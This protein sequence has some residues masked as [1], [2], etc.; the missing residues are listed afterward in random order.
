M[1]VIQGE[2][3]CIRPGGKKKVN[4]INVLR[5]SLDISVIDLYIIFY[6]T[7]L[8]LLSLTRRGGQMSR[9]PASRAGRSRNPKIVGSSLDPAD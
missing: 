9:A 5:C 2:A 1:D 3:G 6:D 8:Y 4:I 7:S